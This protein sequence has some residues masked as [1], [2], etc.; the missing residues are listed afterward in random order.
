MLVGGDCLWIEGNDLLAGGNKIV[1]LLNSIHKLPDLF[2]LSLNAI[3]VQFSNCET[4]QFF[5]K[6]GLLVKQ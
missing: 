1:I 3:Q 4:L 2:T 6:T 5:Y